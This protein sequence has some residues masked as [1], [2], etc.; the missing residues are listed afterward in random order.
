M[1][2]DAGAP[3]SPCERWWIARRAKRVRGMPQLAPIPVILI[4]EPGHFVPLDGDTAFVRLPTNSGH[5]H[6]DGEACVA[7]AGQSDVR[8]LLYNLLEERRRDMRPDFLRVVVD[9]SA[10]ANPQQVVLALTGKLPAQALRDHM[11]AR[12]FYLAGTA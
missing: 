12:M 10:V 4:T 1:R 11:V 6:A 8:A 9:A 5:G 7:C 2:A 3:L